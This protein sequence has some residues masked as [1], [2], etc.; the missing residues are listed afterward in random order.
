MNKKR[1]LASELAAANGISEQALREIQ[2]EQARSVVFAQ[3]RKAARIRF[4]AIAAWATTI[5]V[6]FASMWVA[7][8]LLFGIEDVGA[9]PRVALTVMAMIGMLGMMAFVVAVIASVAWYFSARTASLTAIDARLGE[10]EVILRAEAQAA[11]QPSR[12]HA[13]ENG[14]AT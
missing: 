13:G 11:G 6:I 4:I 10:L 2:R 7:V 5:I 3:K 1:D 14:V 12:N 8:A 9:P